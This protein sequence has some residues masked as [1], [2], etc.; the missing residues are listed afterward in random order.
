MSS[1]R[2]IPAIVALTMIAMAGFAGA[3]AA[4]TDPV[5]VVEGVIFLAV[6]LVFVL[7]PMA[8]AVALLCA[9]IPFADWKP[10]PAPYGITTLIVG[11]VL[12]R[13][14]LTS[15]AQLPAPIKRSWAMMVIAAAL[16]VPSAFWGPA[17]V[18][19]R[20][21]RL[22]TIASFLAIVFIVAREVGGPRWKTIERVLLAELV[23][24]LAIAMVELASQ[25]WLL[26]LPKPEIVSARGSVAGVELFTGEVFRPRGIA[27][28]PYGWGQFLA[29]TM[30]IVWL[31]LADALRQRGF[32]GALWWIALA[33]LQAS[34]LLASLSR[35]SWLEAAVAAVVFLGILQLDVQRRRVALILTIMLVPIGVGAVLNNATSVTYR[36]ESAT[37]A[38]TLDIRAKT[39]SDALAMGVDHLPFG[40]GLNSFVATSPERYGVSFSA[41]NSL[42]E[43][44]ADSGLLGLVG[45]LMLALIPLMGV[46]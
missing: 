43:A 21:A 31:R 42:W 14:L 23:V 20:A 37:S 1:S 10:G 22:L 44:T 9:T 24:G 2:V 6:A 4:V 8:W 46:S 15:R 7:A 17:T 3:G 16:F 18:N 12:V 11:V 41:Y 25:R 29:I 34:A 19:D 26:P 5:V 35:K 13:M 33:G 32:G 40:A 39:A 38:Q 28:S 36:L 45:V 30:P 27:L